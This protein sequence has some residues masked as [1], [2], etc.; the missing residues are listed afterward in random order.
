MISETTREARAYRQAACGLLTCATDGRVLEI[1]DTLRRWLG[2]NQDHPL[3]SLFEILTP[4]SL[5]FFEMQLRPLLALGRTVDGAFLTLQCADGRALPVVL[6][7]LQAVGSDE[8]DLAFLVVREREQY[9]ARLRESQ[10]EAELALDALSAAAHAHKMQAVGQMAA[11]VAHEFNNLLAVVRGNIQFAEQGVQLAL[12]HDI[13][14]GGDLTNALSATDKAIGIVRQLLAFTGRQIVRRT[15]L[16]VNTV[17]KESAQLLR[18]ALGRDVTWQ[19]RFAAG[20]PAIFAASDQ[21]QHVITALVL[22]ARDAIREAGRP[23]LIEVSTHA[24]ALAPDARPG[25][26][27]VVRDTGCGMSAEVLQRAIDPFFTTKAVGRGTGLGLSM[28][29]GAVSA[30]GGTTRIASTPGVGT[31]VTIEVPGA[32]D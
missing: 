5:L 21:L 27:L 8:I 25:V 18:P 14:I 19:T 10:R 3:P 16:D 32:T 9:E 11:G 20:V 4:A 17:I 30:L 13:E 24:I 29:Y 2:Q 1:N 31:E 6:N 28:V 12:P 26:R 23:G 7:A 22:N 15:R